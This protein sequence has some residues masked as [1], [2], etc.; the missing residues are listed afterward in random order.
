MPK[1]PLTHVRS[2]TTASLKESQDRI[3]EL[4]QIMTMAAKIS[5][6]YKIY[7][8]ICKAQW[9]FELTSTERLLDRVQ[10]RGVGREIENET[11]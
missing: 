8:H 7:Q 11:P 3:M 5:F 10:I 2:N 4:A 9:N 6:Y 1:P